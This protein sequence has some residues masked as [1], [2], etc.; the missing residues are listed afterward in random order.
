M[1]TIISLTPKKPD[2]NLLDFCEAEN[3]TN[4]HVQVDKFKE[5]VTLTHAHVKQ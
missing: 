1:K 5:N 2:S 4:I 3:I